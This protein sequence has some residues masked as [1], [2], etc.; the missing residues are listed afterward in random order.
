LAGDY[1]IPGFVTIF[2]SIIMFLIFLFQYTLWCDQ[3]SGEEASGNQ[4]SDDRDKE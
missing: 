3:A 4:E 2:A 1:K